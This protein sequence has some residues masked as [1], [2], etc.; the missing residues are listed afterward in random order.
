[1]DILIHNV[2]KA[3]QERKVFEDFS[4]C[5]SEGKITCLMGNSGEGKTTLFRLMSGLDKPDAGRIEGIPETVS[6]CFQEDRL[7]E[8]FG[9]VA[10]IHLMNR[11]LEKAEIEKALLHV[12]LKQEDMMSPVSQF[13]GGMK[14]RV[15]VVQ[16]LL[17]EG[18]LV[19][20]DEPFAGLDQETK[21]LVISFILENQRDRTILLSTHEE[22][23]VVLLGALKKEL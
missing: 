8:E 19:L 16:T 5:F 13:S 18:K 15:S 7:V 10:N 17:S 21:M 11:R 12:G 9:A 22:Q 4:M 20:L 6:L 2:S 23:D 14:R 3:F 1:M